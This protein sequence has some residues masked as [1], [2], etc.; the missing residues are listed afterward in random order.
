MFQLFLE[1]YSCS[2]IAKQNPPF[3]EIDL[4]YCRKKYNW[5]IE[6]DKYAME[7]QQ[8]VREKLMKTKLESLEFLSNT[9]AAS[10][11]YHNA[12]LL[13]YIQSG[14]EEDKPE[15]LISGTTSYKAIIETIAKL[16][17]ED[18]ITTQNVN[19]TS[20]V[21]IEN[22]KSETARVVSSDE[23]KAKFKKILGDDK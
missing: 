1:G 5:D 13:K 6:K 21:V 8:R 4:L 11:K 7:L 14:K 20:N 22:R 17:G 16:T 9:L 15:N 10:H 19:K 12:Q 18:R 23:R 3:N 2:E